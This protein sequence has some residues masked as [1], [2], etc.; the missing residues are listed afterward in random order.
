MPTVSV[1]DLAVAG[2]DLVVGTLGRS[3][4]ILDDLTPVREMSPEIAAAPEHLFEPLPAVRWRY[5]SAPYGS[6]VGAGKNPPK[7]AII[8]YF[9]KEKPEGEVTLEVLDADGELVRRLS[10]KL[11]TPYTP[12]DHPDRSPT[13]KP[14]PELKVEKGLNRASWDLA[15]AGAEMGP[16]S[17]D[18]HRDAETRPAGAA[19]RLHPAADGRWPG[20]DT[21]AAGRA[22]PAFVGL[23][24]RPHSSSTPSPSGSGSKW[25]G[26][27]LWSRSSAGSASR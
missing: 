10:S 16:R 17:P 13:A 6:S 5:A 20:V 15:Y 8:T 23:H 9:L 26:S 27:S 22:R 21:V 3:A 2:D 14:K 24:V 25:Q 4:W 12:E 11:K 7:G 19:R 18:R 1:V